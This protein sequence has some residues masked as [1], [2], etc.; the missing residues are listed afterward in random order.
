[1]SSSLIS[2]SLRQAVRP[3]LRQRVRLNS[4]QAAPE[5]KAQEAVKNAQKNA[6]QA[7]DSAMKTLGPA[8]AK[9][10]AF[11]TSTLQRLGPAGKKAADFIGREHPRPAD[12]ILLLPPLIARTA[13]RT[14]FT[15]NFAVFREIV[16]QVYRAELTPPKDLATVRAAYETLYKRAI[17]PTYWRGI[18][19]SGEIARVGL[20]AAEAYG[21]YKVHWRNHRTQADCWV[22]LTLDPLSRES[23]RVV[24]DPGVM[25]SSVFVY[26]YHHMYVLCSSG[27]LPVELLLSASGS[28]VRWV[29]LTSIS[30]VG[31]AVMQTASCSVLGLLAT[32]LSWGKRLHL[33]RPEFRTQAEVL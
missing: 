33:P 26:A 25:P 7:L 28:E 23:H 8:A 2:T 12:I 5:Q 19:Q 18:I 21:I 10:E 16:K 24:Y 14:S 31:P 32:F 3:A 27:S 13:A 22:P 29:S 6:S 20:Y 9:A 4:S 17:D 11:A 1:M 30:L 15:Y